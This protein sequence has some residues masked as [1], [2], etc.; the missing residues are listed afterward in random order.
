M[1]VKISIDNI[2]IYLYYYCYYQYLNCGLARVHL[3]AHSDDGHFFS[4]PPS[5]MA[6]GEAMPAAYASVGLAVTIRKYGLFR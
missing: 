6:I 4:P 5:L 2:N 3:H 1:L